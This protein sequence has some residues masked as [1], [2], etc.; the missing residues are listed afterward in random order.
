LEGSR[1][2]THGLDAIREAHQRVQS[3]YGDNINILIVG[4]LNRHDQLWGGNHVATRNRQGE[5][6]PI[7][8]LMADWGL[9]SLLPRGIFTR[10]EGPHQLTID[11]VLVSTDLS[12]RVTRCHIHPVEHESDHRAIRTT[13]QCERPPTPPPK[14]PFSFREGPT[15]QEAK[16]RY[17][18]ERLVCSA[19]VQEYHVMIQE[20]LEYSY[21]TNGIARVLLRVP[22]DDP[23]TLYYFLCDPN[24]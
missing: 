9:I 15:N 6:E 19:L 11:L 16:L 10:K 17:N 8:L 20:G 21:V 23:G 13:F 22:H 5:A 12:R 4:D 18:A 24:S 3:E 7:V 1:T 14:A 2:L